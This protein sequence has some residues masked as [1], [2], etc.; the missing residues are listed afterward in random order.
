MLYSCTMVGKHSSVGCCCSRLRI[1]DGGKSPTRA[2]I[3]RYLVAHADTIHNI[4]V[5]QYDHDLPYEFGMFRGCLLRNLSRGY[6][7]T[8]EQRLFERLSA[9]GG[10]DQQVMALH[11]TTVSTYGDGL[12]PMARQGYNKDG[13]GLDT[14]NVLF[15]LAHQSASRHDGFEREHSDVVSQCSMRSSV[16]KPTI[17][18]QLVF[19]TTASSVE[20]TSAP[21]LHHVGFTMRATLS[22]T[23]S[24]PHR[25]RRASCA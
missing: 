9:I 17:E 24:S 22:D 1:P 13:D 7:S 12:K 6:D 19:C 10:P 15:L 23:R 4:D 3:A 20:T 8:G 2:P 18:A 16:S 11:S 5:W 14:F 25:A 21:S